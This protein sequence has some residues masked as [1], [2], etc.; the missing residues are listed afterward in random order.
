M[1][2]CFAPILPGPNNEPLYILNPNNDPT[3]PLGPYGICY[4]LETCQGF[5]DAPQSRCRDCNQDYCPNCHNECPHCYILNPNNVLAIHLGPYGTCDGHDCQNLNVD[6]GLV[7][8]CSLGHDFCL[9]CH[10]VCPFCFPFTC[11]QDGINLLN[12]FN[13]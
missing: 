10:Y 8:T 1:S 13:R 2:I 4:G 11:E 3:I 6:D 5:Y 9:D 7:R 12:I